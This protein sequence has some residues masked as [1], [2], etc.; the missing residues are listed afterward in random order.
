[1]ALGKAQGL[2]V[3]RQKEIDRL[4]EKV[5]VLN[6][7]IVDQSLTVDSSIEKDNFK[8]KTLEFLGR[9]I[10][11]IPQPLQHLELDAETN[12]Y[13]TTGDDPAFLLK[14]KRSSDMPGGWARLTIKMIYLEESGS[15]QLYWDD[16]QGFSESKSCRVPIP[17]KGQSE[18]LLCLPPLVRS[19]RLDPASSS[20]FKL[21]HIQIRRLLTISIYSRLILSNFIKIF[22]NPGKYSRLFWEVCVV[23]RNRGLRPIKEAFYKWIKSSSPS[24]FKHHIHAEFKSLGLDNANH[25][26]SRNLSRG[27]PSTVSN[28]LIFKLAA[29][30]RGDKIGVGLIEHLGDIVACEPI[31]RYLKKENPKAHIFW[32]VKGEYRELVAHNPN[33]DSVIVVDCLTDWIK[34]VYHNSFD[35]VV[36]LHVNGRI[37]QDCGVPL[38]KIQGNPEITGDNYFHYGSLLKS[39]CLGAGIKD[40]DEQPRIYITNE[41]KEAVNQFSLPEKFIVVHCFSNNPD[42]DWEPSKWAEFAARMREKTGLP[43]I[44]VGLQG[45]LYEPNHEFNYCG[46]LSILETAELIRRA[47]LFVGVDSGPAQLANAVQTPGV[48]LLGRLGPFKKYNPYSGGYADGS[49]ASLVYN[50]T[51]PAALLPIDSVFQAAMERIGKSCQV[52]EGLAQANLASNAAIAT[53]LY[54]SS[55]P[56]AKNL[57]PRIIAFYL[58][59]YH[60]I[61]Q[62]DQNWGKGFT[63]WRNVGKSMPF[64]KGQYQPRL[65]GELGYYDLRVPEIMEHQAELAQEHGID[66]FC[67]YFYWFNGERLLHKPIDNMLKSKKINIPFCFCWANE[68]WTRRWDGM[69]QEIIVKQEHSPQD[70]LNFIRYLIP[71]FNDPRYIHINGKPLLLVYR[72]EL[73]PDPRRTAELWRNEVRKAGLGDLYLV[74]CEGFDP[75]TNPEDIGFDASYEVPTFILP[76]ELLYDDIRNLDVSPEFKGRIFDY[77]KI[78]RYY[79]ER[80]TPPYKR[81]RDIML[82]W[83][84]SPRHGRNAVIFH[85]VTPDKYAD[86]LRNSLHHAMKHFR[87]EERLVFINAWNEWAEGSYLEPDLKY[88]RSF[89][90]ATRDVVKNCS[91]MSDRKNIR[92]SLLP[93]LRSVGT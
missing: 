51:G 46:R 81:Y 8:L 65:P 38:H 47:T 68:N 63:E 13:H 23:C 50:E 14:P 89:L 49:L 37:C 83:D 91:P 36:D 77:S 84:N 12:I 40:L 88:G 62:N 10:T 41:T 48:V 54:E 11:L 74:R 43:I 78:V 44:E 92:D 90:E 82:A 72:T 73:F 93:P 7:T 24:A 33:I 53:S 6:K 30:S 67:Y 4:R 20:R 26:P 56:D 57:R 19:L 17:V 15:L 69:D 21:T 16:G 58:P 86:W 9:V 31:A 18:M 25:I 71:I 85:G 29:N 2:A 42:K 66:G 39:F 76:N 45:A 70:D 59:Q 64:Y 60:P 75:Y 28:S 55:E 5:S 35:R 80:E 87:G 52:S 22:R 79:C 34:M 32:V 3:A 61:P 1:M 27:S